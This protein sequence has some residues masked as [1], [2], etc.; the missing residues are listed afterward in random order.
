MQSIQCFAEKKINTLLVIIK[1]NFME[2]LP[3]T[4]IKSQRQ[5]NKYCSILEELVTA[6]SKTKLH[7]DTI[8]LLTVLIE[9][10]DSEHNSFADE[11]PVELL[12][13]L[14]TE[15]N[16]KAVE[17]ANLLGVSKSLISDILH[18]RRSFSKDII[19]KLSEHFK[20]S[21]EAFNRPYE[22]KITQH[23]NGAKVINGGKKILA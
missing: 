14:L 6:K 21:Q 4:V 3:Y 16:L 17:L 8:E 20:I 1:Y 18:Y 9:K 2:A 15:N 11:N 5:Y 7:Q 10:W 19:R 22:L 23:L 13:Y 12:K